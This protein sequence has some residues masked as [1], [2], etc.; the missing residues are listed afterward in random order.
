MFACRSAS[1]WLTLVAARA[2]FAA[3]N[4]QP[5]ERVAVVVADAPGVDLAPFRALIERADLLIAADGGARYLLHLDIIPHL[6]VGDFDS[7]DEA[8]LE[9]LVA[10][11]IEVQ[12]HPIHKNETDLELALLAAIARG[13]TCIYVLAAL[14]GRADQ[15]LA[16]LQLLTHP[17]IMQADVRLLQDRWE[18]WAIRGHVRIYGHSGDLLS[19]LPMTEEVT[20]IVTE[21]LYYPLRGETLRLGP[22]R[23]VSN[24]LLGAEA[25]VTIR[26]GILLCMHERRAV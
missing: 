9:R 25:R 8:L 14:G 1:A 4:E 17:A 16:N 15:H 5:S 3:M 6:A 2:T 18:V 21:G 7:L 19:L 23:G 24:V 22:A 20:G 12:R 10:G 11:G 13:A 26:S